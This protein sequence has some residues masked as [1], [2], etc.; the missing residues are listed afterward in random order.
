MNHRIIL[1]VFLISFST[2]I[3]SAKIKDFIILP[4]IPDLRDMK[5]LSQIRHLLS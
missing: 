3:L 4:L 2:N 1:I 5:C